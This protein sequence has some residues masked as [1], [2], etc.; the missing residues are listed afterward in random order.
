MPAEQARSLMNAVRERASIGLTAREHGD[1]GLTQHLRERLLA[2]D[3]THDD[4]LRRLKD[5]DVAGLE[6]G[7]AL[8]ARLDT[9]KARKLLYHPDRRH[10]VALCVAAGFSTPTT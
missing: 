9:S 4:L 8:H 5:G 2:G 6:I 7:L 3:L 10:M 1:R